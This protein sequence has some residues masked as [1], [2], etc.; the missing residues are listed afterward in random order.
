[1]RS[2]Q[3]QFIGALR[4][5]PKPLKSLSIDTAFL[6]LDSFDRV[7]AVCSHGHPIGQDN[8]TLLYQVP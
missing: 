1:M 5:R 3:Q 7:G 4:V 2:F 8:R 6:E